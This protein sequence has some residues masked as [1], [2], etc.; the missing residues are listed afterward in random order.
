MLGQPVQGAV[1]IDNVPD[2]GEWK[3][4]WDHITFSGFLGVRMNLQFTWQGCD[5]ALAA[6]LVL[7][8]ARLIA[9]AHEAGVA[10]PFDAAGF[11]FKDP[12]PAS[13]GAAVEHR[14]AEQYAALLRWISGLA[15]SP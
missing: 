12:V 9:R 14:L 10:G 2:L 3:T 5:S 4:A 11:F 1:H 13:P 6:P 15:E 8:L 7:D